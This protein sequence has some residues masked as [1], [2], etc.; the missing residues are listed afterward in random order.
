MQDESLILTAAKSL[1]DGDAD[2]DATGIAPFLSYLHTTDAVHIGG[3]MH[4]TLN[5][6]V[7][8]S[9]VFNPVGAECIIR[10]QV[11]PVSTYLDIVTLA[12]AVGTFAVI[13]IA[14]VETTSAAIE[15]GELTI[16]L[17]RRPIAGDFIQLLIWVFPSTGTD[18]IDQGRINARITHYDDNA[19]Y[20]FPN[21][22]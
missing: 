15:R 1:A 13:P 18:G 20:P 3:A 7:S 22:I 10:I 14:T 12:T 8:P 5:V 9:S 21:G 19:S 16:P 2:L 11:C 6:R 17:S 4:D